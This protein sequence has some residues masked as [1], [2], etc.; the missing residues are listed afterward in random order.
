MIG[1]RRPCH[2]GLS[3]VYVNPF[4]RQRKEFRVDKLRTE[5]GV[6]EY[7]VTR[8]SEAAPYVAPEQFTL[9]VKK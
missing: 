7:L 8:K 2:T 4:M 5:F 6:T 1:K 3:V 9:E